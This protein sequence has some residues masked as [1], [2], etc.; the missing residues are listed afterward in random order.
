[1]F[2]KKILDVFVGMAER[3]HTGVL[4]SL[5]EEDHWLPIMRKKN[6]EWGK[7]HCQA[8]WKQWWIIII[9]AKICVCDKGNK[10]L[11]ESS[12]ICEQSSMCKCKY[13]YVYE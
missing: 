13:N 4:L 9:N 1:M 8:V 5:V 12:C 7:M 6:G 3:N 11:G 10:S 2:E